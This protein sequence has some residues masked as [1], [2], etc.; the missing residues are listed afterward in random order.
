MR[1]LKWILAAA[2]A[3]IV[4]GSV[5]AYWLNPP[6]RVPVTALEEPDHDLSKDG[7]PRVRGLTYTQVENGV[8]KWTMSAEGA[9]LDEAEGKATLTHVRIK[10][11]PDKGGWYTLRGDQG[12]Y[13]QK[14]KVVTLRGN[15]HGRSH[16]GMTLVTEV[17]TYTEEQKVVETDTEVTVAGPRYKVHGRGMTVKVPQDHVTFRG[18]VHSTF[19]PVGEGPP[20]GATAAEES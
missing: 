2:L 1:R 3:A 17:L 11:Y 8:K 15:V 7:R 13:D 16:D 14:K 12:E 5:A 9:R 10:F 20:P 18:R 4:A 19:I 6:V